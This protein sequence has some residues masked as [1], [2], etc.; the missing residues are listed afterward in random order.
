[1]G[2]VNPETN[3]RPRVR[4]LFEALV[5]LEPDERRARV[6]GLSLPDDLRRKLQAMF[7]ADRTPQPLLSMAAVDIVDHFRGDEDLVL[8][9]IGSMVGSFRLLALIGEGGSS[10]VFRAERAAGSGAQTVALKLLRT[11][12][13]SVDGQ[14]RFR[15][16][17]SILAQLTHP[18][19]AHLIEAGI[20]DAGIPYIAMEFIDGR[21]ITEDADARA[22]SLRDRL[23][24]FATLC[25]AIDT[26]HAALVVHRD[27]KPS[28]VFVTRQGDLK[29]LDFGIAKLLDDDDGA[30]RTQSIALTPEY[31]APEQF[32]VGPVTVAADIYALGVLLGELLTGQR[33]SGSAQTRA[34]ARVLAAQENLSPPGLASREALARQLRGDLDAIIGNAIVEEPALRY[35]SACALADDV[36]CYL[37]RRPVRAHP[38]SGWYRA[39]KFVA[40]HRG[41]V[42]I[43][44]LFIVGILAALGLALWQAT[45]AQRQTSV[46]REHA[47]RAEAVRQFLVGVFEHASPDE[48]R[49][50]PID[51]RQLL[52][53]GEQ[54]ID[55]GLRDQP[56]LQADVLTVLGQL[57]LELSEFKRA[58]ALLKRALEISSAVDI[59]PDVRARAL[60]GA[61]WV[62]NETEAFAAATANAEQALAILE[63]MDHANP[64]AIANAH[65]QIAKSLVG[66]GDTSGL[67]ARLRETLKQD[68][69]AL[70]DRN[71]Y[72]ADQW[73]LLGQRLGDQGRYEESERAFRIGIDGYRA[74]FGENS[75]RVAH[76]LN[77]LSN[78][79]DDKGDLLGSEAALRRALK[80]R[81]ETVG[82]NHHDTLTVRNN[83]SATLEA[84]GKFAQALPLRLELLRQFEHSGLLHDRDLVASY[85]NIG[86]DYRET[87]RL[88]ESEA[89]LR[90]SLEI[91][92]KAQG[93]RSTW[94]ISTLGNL[95]KLHVLQGRFAPALEDFRE[96]LSI[97]TE[98]NP[99][100]SPLMGLLRAEIGNTLRLQ[101]R[102]PEALEELRL[103][104]ATFTAAI[105][106]TNPWRPN[107]L[108]AL[109]EAQL[110]SGDPVQA[111]ATAQDALSY[112]NRAIAPDHVFSGIAR[113]ALARAELSL[114]HF[115]AA[116]VLLRATLALRSTTYPP[117]D[118]RVLET[119]VEL[120][121]ALHAQAKDAD[122]QA[123][124]IDIGPALKATGSPYARDLELRMVVTTP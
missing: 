2:D 65:H 47:E 124:K 50:Q 81:L 9:L 13:F 104:A 67:E 3:D 34:S 120:M 100:A 117:N 41:V 37:D 82:E 36:D 71:E 62:D 26:A 54:Q 33:L 89:P 22:L 66:K 94:R 70:G 55:S 59:P 48:N 15:R 20:S 16:E 102:Y 119:K 38:P 42:A 57:Y 116:E 39:R 112:A 29:V 17:Q 122:A 49:G 114:G 84:Q 103:A 23:R 92:E 73:L 32:G 123:L 72:V 111:Q 74:V 109:S 46:A 31:A 68:R 11:G 27:L 77:E 93:A 8:G 107:V 5:D 1:M 24:L 60:L 19:I 30:T 78:M 88:E 90:K 80:I 99:T 14:R 85:S 115:E 86:K 63:R 18:N 106:P 83:L 44:T 58:D 118:I 76:A 56:A 113:Y 43:T 21:P 110:D 64:D 95:G 108:A 79:L 40:R 97:A 4:D 53:K 45:V 35:R 69:A 6:D 25:R 98:G 7:D 121:R 51:A 105:A 101:H 52:A 61:A 10:A 96:A 12:L 87:G 91:A 75:N 28:N